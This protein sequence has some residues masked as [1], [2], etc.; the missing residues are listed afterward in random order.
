[1]ALE[2][3]RAGEDRGV[4]FD[5]GELEIL[6]QRRWQR[7]AVPAPE[8]GLRVEEVEL[9]RPTGHEEKNDV[10]GGTGE[11]GLFRRQRA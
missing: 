10:L 5:E 11:V 6:R 2:L 3:P 7:F 4:R 8:L 9:A 1:M